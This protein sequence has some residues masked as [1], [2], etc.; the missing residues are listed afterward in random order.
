[1]LSRK[2][3]ARVEDVEKL[4]RKKDKTRLLA[5]CKGKKTKAKQSTRKQKKKQETF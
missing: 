3:T 2:K 1:V 4:G 5:C